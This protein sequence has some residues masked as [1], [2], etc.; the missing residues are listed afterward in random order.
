[1]ADGKEAL[2]RF[3]R[4]DLVSL[5]DA[6]GLFGCS[7]R[8]L[9]RDLEKNQVPVV[10]GMV[11]V[12]ALRATMLPASAA[13]R[14]RVDEVELLGRLLDPYGLE[15]SSS[16]KGRGLHVTLRARESRKLGAPDLSVEGGAYEPLRLKKGDE[17]AA[18]LYVTNRMS[19][20]AARFSPSGFLR[21]K[22]PPLY[23][24]LAREEKRLWLCRR[25][26]LVDFARAF[27]EGE[28]TN[29]D[30]GALGWWGPEV[31]STG[32]SLRIWFRVGPT[33]LDLRHRVRDARDRI[34][35]VED[36]DA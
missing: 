8:K 9:R 12:A 2:G 30:A 31:P 6:A 35:E 14:D 28:S 18:R 20:S 32:G 4:D 21:E 17:V 13:R 36:G 29:D 26:E 24:F 5:E 34:I 3:I 16:R 1:M 19:G 23:L 11:S 15:V 7:V 27:Y 10:A 25:E 22:A 33:S